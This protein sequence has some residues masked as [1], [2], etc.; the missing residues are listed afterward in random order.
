MAPVGEPARPAHRGT[1]LDRVT[2]RYLN[3]EDEQQRPRTVFPLAPEHRLDLFA[4]RARL[5]WLAPVVDAEYGSSTFT[6]ADRA[7]TYEVLVSTTGHAGAGN[8]IALLEPDPQY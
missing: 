6:R 1:R 8:P 5:P 3:I 2:G 4:W 7:A